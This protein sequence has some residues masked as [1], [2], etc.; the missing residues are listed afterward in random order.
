MQSHHQHHHQDHSS[1]WY[2]VLQISLFQNS[3]TIQPVQI[4]YSIERDASAKFGKVFQ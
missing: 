4:L 2:T 3:H 1:R